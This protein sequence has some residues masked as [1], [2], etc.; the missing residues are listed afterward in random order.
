MSSSCHR[1][2]LVVHIKEM[3]L[4]CRVCG[5]ELKKSHWGRHLQSRKH[6]IECGE[7]VVEEAEKNSAENVKD[8]RCWKC[9]GER[10]LLV[11]D[12]LLKKK[13]ESC[14]RDT[15]K[16][17]NQEYNRREVKCEVCGCRVKKCN[18]LRYLGTK[19]SIW[20]F[21]IDMMGEISL[22][23]LR[24]KGEKLNC[25]ARQSTT[26]TI[27]IWRRRLLVLILPSEGWK[28]R[29][30]L[31][32]AV[33]QGADVFLLDEPTNHLDS[34]A[35]QLQGSAVYSPFQNELTKLY[36]SRNLV[37]LAIDCWEFFLHWPLIRTPLHLRL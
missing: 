31:A 17:Y 21:K 16:T 8:V 24:G 7:I 4:D 35:S 32:C 2:R 37:D 18:W 15:R 11:M 1:E 5:C 6:G 34:V 10:M 29:L 13:I 27:S 19:K 30:A 14:R 23:R 3:K 36:L 25:A 28:M 20:E 12:A 33:A 22:T 9:F 26:L